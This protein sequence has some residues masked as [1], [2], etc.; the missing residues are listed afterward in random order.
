MILE[1]SR[2]DVLCS[3]R[4]ALS[5]IDLYSCERRSISNYITIGCSFRTGIAAH[6]KH[7]MTLL[8]RIVLMIRIFVRHSRRFLLRGMLYIVNW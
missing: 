4:N 1:E 5:K 3:G 2:K 7:R 8:V 6:G